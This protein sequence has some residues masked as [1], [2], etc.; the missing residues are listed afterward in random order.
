MEGLCMTVMETIPKNWDSFH[1]DSK[2]GIFINIL[3][4]DY[5]RVSKRRV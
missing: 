1:G 5:F 3:I 4:V 2:I